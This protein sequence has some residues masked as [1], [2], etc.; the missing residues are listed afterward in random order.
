MGSRNQTGDDDI[1]V[2][3]GRRVKRS[4]DRIGVL[5]V[6]RHVLD[7]QLSFGVLVLHMHLHGV[8]RLGVASQRHYR[9]RESIYFRLMGGDD[10]LLLRLHHFRHRADGVKLDVIQSKVIT[11]IE[12]VVIEV[13][14]GDSHIITILVGEERLRTL[15]PDIIAELGVCQ[16]Q[17][18]RL[19]HFRVILDTEFEPCGIVHLAVV[20]DVR[21]PEREHIGRTFLQLQLAAGSR[22]CVPCFL[23]GSFLTRSC[24]KEGEVRTGFSFHLGVRRV[25]MIGT[26]DYRKTVALLAL[27]QRTGIVEIHLRSAVVVY[28]PEIIIADGTLVLVGTITGSVLIIAVLDDILHRTAGR[29]ILLV[30]IGGGRVLGVRIDDEYLRCAFDRIAVSEPDIGVRR[31]IVF[32]CEHKGLS[33]Q[34]I[35]IHHFHRL[36]GIRYINGDLLGAVGL[37]AC[38]ISRCRSFLSVLSSS[39]H[40]VQRESLRTL[41]VGDRRRDTVARDHQITACLAE[42][43]HT[44]Q[45]IGVIIG[46][47]IRDRCLKRGNLA[48]Q[49]TTGGIGLDLNQ[50]PSGGDRG[51][52][53]IIDLAVGQRSR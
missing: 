18:S 5:C 3:G 28:A 35:H 11:Y 26:A 49:I 47:H 8:V 42:S 10:E 36:A 24:I 45:R 48:I 25:E 20:I 19:P 32:R 44:V 41:R 27:C 30:G 34:R 4:R 43:H 51:V 23:I 38:E 21:C 46:V 14:H 17:F 12:N 22:R 7:D 13:H 31:V 52:Q 9:C 1:L 50:S 15:M 37:I 33:R 6:R 40:T 39:R 53:I 2:Q 16:V 29:I